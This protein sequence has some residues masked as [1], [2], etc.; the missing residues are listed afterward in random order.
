MVYAVEALDPEECP[1]LICYTVKPVVSGNYLIRVCNGKPYA[2][3]KVDTS[4]VL[5]V[6]EETRNENG[7][8]G[9]TYGVAPVSTQKNSMLTV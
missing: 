1:S 9:D 2:S 5:F 4:S 8:D 3:A 6:Y 7:D